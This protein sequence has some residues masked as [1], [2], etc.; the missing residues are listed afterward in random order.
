MPQRMLVLG[1]FVMACCWKVERLPSAGETVTAS[2]LSIEPG[3]KGLNV[4]IGAQRLGMSVDVLLGIGH[5]AAGR[6]LQHLL[7]QEGMGSEHVHA[8]APQSGY[9]A[10]MIGEQ[11]QNAIA[12]F[13]GPNLLLQAQHADMAG[14][15]I[16]HASCVYGQ[17]ET[18]DA[19]IT[20]AFQIARAHGVRTVLNPS[21]WRSIPAECLQCTDIL[22]VNEVEVV[23]LL[24]LGEPLPHGSLSQARQCI[25]AALP[26]WWE[27][28][29]G[30]LV[31]VTLGV[32][33]SVAFARSGDVQEA[34]A[35]PVQAI[36]TV[37]CGDAFA[38]GF[39]D[40]LSCGL[41][42][43]QSLQSGNA[44]GAL[45][46]AHWGVLQALPTQADVRQILQTQAG[47]KCP[48]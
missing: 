41:G 44:C 18:S 3:G 24:G 35:F 21:P 42:L 10:G 20:R 14:D 32:L 37:G 2:A 19:V 1:S 39:C 26:R 5:D 48:T 30:S 23:S 12:V 13:P 17:F 11:G 25:E 28:T 27:A 9:G 31:V 40:A 33:G 6:Q 45:M 15:A 22:I 47:L 36:D 46:A 8:L 29:Q 16:A 34:V 43:G 7:V 4:A 38:A